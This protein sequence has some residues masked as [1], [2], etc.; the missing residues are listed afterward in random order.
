MSGAANLGGGESGA[1]WLTVVLP[2]FNE[3]DSIVEL[4]TSLREILTRA[5]ISHEI[6]VIDDAS[7][8]GT[9]RKVAEAFGDTVAVTV[10]TQDHG[11]A[12]SLLAGVRQARGRRLLLMDSDFNHQPADVPRLL[13]LAGS[14][15]LVVGSRYVAGGG[16]PHAPIRQRLSLLF[17]LF[18]RAALRGP[19]RDNL[20]GFI[21]IDRE[22]LLQLPLASIFTGYGDYCI[23]LLHAAHRAGFR[24]CETP[25]QY[26]ARLGGRSGI[27]FVYH[28]I[29]YSKVVL[30]LR[31]SDMAG[32]GGG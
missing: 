3:A 18:I 15:D 6:L 25:V 22:R 4:L 10:R 8:D 2:T 20:S 1:P 5:G 14:A 29:Q 11:L 21:C 16:M 26:G 30:A 13:A 24:L 12:A 17:N 32:R 27:R 9:A 19:V 28:A 7:P 23:R 31:R